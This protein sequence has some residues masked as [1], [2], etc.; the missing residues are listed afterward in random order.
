[1]AKKAEQKSLADKLAD[2]PVHK[3]GDEAEYP[4]SW[5]YRI[6]GNVIIGKIVNRSNGI[7][8]PLGT[9]DLIEIE[10]TNING[11]ELAKAET[12]TVWLTKV[13]KTEIER[14]KIDIGDGIGLKALGKRPG[15][16]YYDFVVLK[17]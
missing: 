12:R 1:M 9:S 16:R 7:V 3:E 8:T 10:A 15:K 17:Q 5:N 11:K 6:P 4:E 2:V 14:L 13:L